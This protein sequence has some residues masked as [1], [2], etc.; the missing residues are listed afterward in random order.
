MNLFRMEERREGERER[1]RSDLSKDRKQRKK[2]EDGRQKYKTEEPSANLS[3]LI[4]IS[5]ILI[6]L[7]FDWL[8]A[9]MTS[10]E[11]WALRLISHLGPRQHW[12]TS[13]SRERCISWNTS[14]KALSVMTLFQR[15][16]VLRCWLYRK[17]GKDLSHENFNWFIKSSHKI[18]KES[19]HAFPSFLTC[20]CCNSLG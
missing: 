9:G 2:N 14:S 7:G 13:C 12:V 8:W 3:E 17:K 20:K 6:H 19:Y 10:E 16:N 4:N 15:V 1:W 18:L 11:D 5:W